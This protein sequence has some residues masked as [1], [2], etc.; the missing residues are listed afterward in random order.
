[1]AQ[2][3]IEFSGRLL[4]AAAEFDQ[5]GEMT[6]LARTAHSLKGSV[7]N[8]GALE[9]MRATEELERT[10]LAGNAPAAKAALDRVTATVSALRAALAVLTE[11]GVAP[12][13]A[14]GSGQLE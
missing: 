6:G 1:V 11:P 8:F 14:L 4:T 10:A 5:A 12:A 3:F 2:T 7:G 9:A 13:A